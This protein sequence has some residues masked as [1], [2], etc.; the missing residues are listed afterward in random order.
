MRY[1][2]AIMLI[3]TSYIKVSALYISEIMYDPNG[4]DTGREWIEIYNDTISSVNLTTW[5]L[6][7]NGTNH[8]ISSYSGGDSIPANKYAIIADNPAKFLA[9]FPS[10][11]GVLYDSV[12]SLINSGEEL[13]L[14]NNSGT[15]I[16]TINY[17]TSIGG[18]NDGTTLSKISGAWVK[19]DAT[20]GE[21]NKLSN[22]VPEV[23]SADSGSNS[24]TTSNQSVIS[25][26][27]PPTADIVIYVPTERTVVVG[28]QSTFS[29]YSMT[30]GGKVID[31]VR[32][33]WAYG[34]GGQGIGATS[35]HTY[36]YPGRYLLYVSGT[37]GYIAGEAR[38]IIHAV[39]ADILIKEY[40]E[41]RYG[42]YIDI[43]NP[44]S[45]EIDMSQWKLMING[46]AFP[47]PER[48]TLLPKST[49]RFSGVTMGFAS[50]TLN[51]YSV[52]RITFPNLEEVTRFVKLKADETDQV[53]SVIPEFV[54]TSIVKNLPQVLGA[55][56][57][58]VKINQNKNTPAMVK[59]AEQL[60]KTTNS[61]SGTEKFSVNIDD[62]SLSSFQKSTTTTVSGIPAIATT[63]RVDTV[64]KDN[65]LISFLKYLFSW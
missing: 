47:F 63:T 48:T 32:Y 2:L 11:Q 62:T 27:S 4:A 36:A 10:Y 54:A 60:E 13:V 24:T 44:N 20:P 26:M 21:E 28:A 38:M 25:Q 50:T 59:K 3:L 35:T 34:D 61:S 33:T 14:K 18:A 1:V 51:D 46:S 55:S 15:A 49:T 45:Y 57:S 7:E 40:G 23:P 6:L 64:K 41:G 65:R 8:S 9:D 31:N 5:K 39:P 22:M 58:T 53:T 43:S 19:G 52:I 16:D 17:D 37:N 30:R 12:F 29:V 42:N 56:S